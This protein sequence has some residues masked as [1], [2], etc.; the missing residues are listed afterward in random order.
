MLDDVRHEEGYGFLHAVAGDQCV[1]Q[2]LHRASPHGGQANGI[3]HR[4]WLVGELI[5]RS[6]DPPAQGGEE[7]SRLTIGR[8]DLLAGKHRV[9]HGIQ[10]VPGDR[11]VEQ[12]GADDPPQSGDRRP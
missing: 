10:S 1:G 11:C 2:I 9:D 5:E 6:S 7:R 8:L 12:A 4:P 3:S